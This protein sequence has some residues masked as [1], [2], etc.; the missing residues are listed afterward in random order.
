M[1]IFISITW[2]SVVALAHGFHLSRMI[3][4]VGQEGFSRKILP[5]VAGSK[6]A[7]PRYNALLRMSIDGTEPITFPP[8]GGAQSLAAGP[9]SSTTLVSDAT[10]NNK[11]KIKVAGLFGLWY[12][13]NVGYNVYNKRVL[14]MV[15]ELTYT[16][17]FLQLFLGL[18]YL[19]P[20]WISGAR[21]APSLNSEDMRNLIPMA[22]LHSLTHLGAVVSMGSGAVSFTHVVKAAEPA[23]SAAM[24]AI[25]LK[26]YLPVSVYLALAPVMAGVALASLT[27]LTFT[28]KAFGGAMVSN[29]A[30]AGRGI[31][32]KGH[33][34]AMKS[35]ESKHMTPSNLY[36][37]MTVMSTAL[38]LPVVLLMEG[39]SLLPTVVKLQ[40]AGV[41][42]T[43]VSQ[44]ALSA[45]FYYFYNDVA[46][47]TLSNVAP[48]THA[49]GNT[50]K[51]VVIILASVLWLG[52]SMTRQGAIGSALAIFGVLLY[53]L[54]NNRSNNNNSN[55]SSSSN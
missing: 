1:R 4:R 13:L 20:L 9:S 19:L 38:C 40:K 3:Q 18:G 27:E 6:L 14:N 43:V 52:S 35:D 30:S 10:Q 16:V 48:V 34:Q 42:G 50:V 47:L 51:R 46:F 7:A 33:M 54:A 25:F 5:E 15:P 11:Q 21:K 12:A 24:S 31:V 36:G 29:V 8:I 39:R 23:V 37:V 26:Q 44:T 2:L 53:S 49:L 32:G 55:K 41:L 45:F 28:W 17:A 22:I